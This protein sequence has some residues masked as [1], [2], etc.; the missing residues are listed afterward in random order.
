MQV[1]GHLEISKQCLAYTFDLPDF[2]FI[3]PLAR[4][5][6]RLH[7]L[8]MAVHETV[9][10]CSDPLHCPRHDFSLFPLSPNLQHFL[11]LDSH[12]Q[13]RTLN[14][15]SL[16]KRRNLNTHTLQ[17]PRVSGHQHCSPLPCS[18]T[19]YCPCPFP[20]PSQRT[21]SPRSPLSLKALYQWSTHLP[22]V[23]VSSCTYHSHHH[24][25]CYFPVFRTLLPHFLHEQPLHFFASFCSETP[26]KSYLNILI[27][28]PFLPYIHFN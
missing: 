19:S 4:A 18:W 24:I 25:C 22:T 28:I 11:P 17:P 6:I 27:P 1:N 14:S 3:C 5:C 2:I 7:K 23:N 26:T 8:Q 12:S 21:F 20:A 13:L 9:R 15:N 10:P 16:R